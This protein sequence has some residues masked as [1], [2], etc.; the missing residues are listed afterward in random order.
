MLQTLNEEP[1]APYTDWGMM[2][3][4]LVTLIGEVPI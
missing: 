3:V 4:Y 2:I 1:T